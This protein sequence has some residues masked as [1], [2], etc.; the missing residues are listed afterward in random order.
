M[1]KELVAAMALLLTTSLLTTI[2]VLADLSEGSTVRHVVLEMGVIGVGVL[3]FLFILRNL[4]GGYRSEIMRNQQEM[5][6]WQEQSDQW[7]QEAQSILRG[8][9][10]QIDRQFTTWSL[11][12]AEKEVALLL[13]K[14]LSFK[15][16]AK[17]RDTKEKT[18]RLQSSAVYK[19]SS[20]SGRAELAAFFLEDLLLPQN[21]PPSLDESS[22]VI[23]PERRGPGSDEDAK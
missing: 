3:G 17:I 4:V 16:I 7:K 2:D 15:E 14:G 22:C 12:A 9:A 23:G 11:T 21:S 1:N 5:R 8:L 18:V 6:L 13:I 20:L 19:K 10:L